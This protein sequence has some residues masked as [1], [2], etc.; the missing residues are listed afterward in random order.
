MFAAAGWQVLT[1]KYGRLLEDCSPGPGGEECA[2]DRRDAQPGISEAVAVRRRELRRRLPGEG[3]G[4]TGSAR[5]S[6]RSRTRCWWTRW[7]TWAATK[8]R[9]ARMRGLLGDRRLAPHGDPRVHH[10]GLRTGQARGTRR[11]IRSLR[12]EE[13]MGG[14]RSSGSGSDSERPGGVLRGEDR[15]R[16]MRRAGGGRWAASQER[17]EGTSCAGGSDRLTS[18]GLPS[19]TAT[20]QAGARPRVA[21]P[22]QRGPGGGPRVVTVARTSGRRRTWA[23]R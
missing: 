12:T 10:Q 4:A 5:W 23:G 20:T 13:Q 8:P 17:A 11:A 16:P 2:R 19:G 7:P 3:P 14:A 1:L 22:D 9:L 6:T 18:G 21:G 15:R